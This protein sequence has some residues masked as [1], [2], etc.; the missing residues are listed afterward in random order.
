MSSP[1]DRISANEFVVKCRSVSSL[2]ELKRLGEVNPIPGQANT[3]LMRL[4]RPVAD[5]RSGW[6]KLRKALGTSWQVLPVFLS[7]DDQPKY[8]V[9]TVQVRF[10]KPPSDAQ[11]R[12][13]LPAGLRVKSRNEYV[14]AQ[15]ELEPSK[16]DEEYLPDLLSK[17]RTT[18][19]EEVTVWPDTLQQFRRS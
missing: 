18:S 6:K 10:S 19:G 5:A 7:D 16:P 8:P 12:S 15:V 2:P 17:L 14:P 4:T 13:W 1:T 11:L 3:Y 9:G